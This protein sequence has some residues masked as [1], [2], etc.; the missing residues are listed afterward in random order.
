MKIRTLLRFGILITMVACST[1]SVIA[2]SENPVCVPPTHESWGTLPGK[3]VSEEGSMKAV[4]QLGA[5]W[6]RVNTFAIDAALRSTRTDHARYRKLGFKILLQTKLNG[7]GGTPSKHPENLSKFKEKLR[8]TLKKFP[9]DIVA[10]E[11]EMDHTHRMYTGTAAQYLDL[12]EATCEI[13]HEAGA[14]CTDGGLSSQAMVKLVVDDLFRSGKVEKALEYA[15]YFAREFKGI[16]KEKI[17]SKQLEKALDDPEIARSRD[18]LFGFKLENRTHRPDYINFH[19]YQRVG[20]GQISDQKQ[21]EVLIAVIEMVRKAGGGIPVMTGE[22]GQTYNAKNASKAE[23][24]L[25][26][27]L[28][29]LT[30]HNVKV[31]VMF[32]GH[33]TEHGKVPGLWNDKG[34]LAPRGRIFRDF[35]QKN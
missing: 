26:A 33:G 25:P 29:T 30:D 32:A 6:V 28:Q 23:A 10:P 31:R 2:V 3:Q 16:A 21:V 27:L 24:L 34:E 8:E 19:W 15:G 9:S 4:C 12:L 14:K 22:F 7:G 35:V 5:A 17:T 20:N 1:P 13:A 18:M 11:N